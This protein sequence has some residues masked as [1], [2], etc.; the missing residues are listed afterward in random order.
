[1]YPINMK[2]RYISYSTYLKN[3]FLHINVMGCS[4]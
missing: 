2:V 1:M 3:Y 4:I